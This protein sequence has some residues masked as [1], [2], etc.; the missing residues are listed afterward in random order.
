MQK[1][2]EN[3]GKIEAIPQEQW[4]TLWTVTAR[5][6][7]ENFVGIF[8]TWLGRRSR[9]KQNPRFEIRIFT[10]KYAI[11]KQP[12]LLLQSSVRIQKIWP[13]VVAIPR[14]SIS[15][16]QALHFMTDAFHTLVPAD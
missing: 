1:F 4:Y 11:A 5:R 14:P 13:Q 2:T 3:P 16:Q 15:P 12:F 6:L 8:G 10:M 7:A 9:I